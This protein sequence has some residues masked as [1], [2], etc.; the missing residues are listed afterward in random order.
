MIRKAT[1]NDINAIAELYDI[2]LD[3]EENSVKLTSWKKG[4]YPTADTAMSGVMSRSA[5]LYEDEKRGILIAS[6]ILDNNQPPEYQQIN[7]G[8]DASCEQVLVIHTLC[9]HPSYAG[10]GIGSDMVNLAK[11]VAL[12]K[13]CIAIRLNTTARNVSAQHLYEKSGFTVVAKQPIMLNGNIACG[14]HLFMEYLI[15]KT[16]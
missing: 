11:S 4:I 8:V 14:D 5:Y 3:H 16:P 12:E 13:N 2:M 15:K 10:V 9:V 6:V 1:V 7:W